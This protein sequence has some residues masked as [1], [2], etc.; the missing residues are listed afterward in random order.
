MESKPFFTLLR[1]RFIWLNL[2]FVGY[3][4]LLQPAVL[5]RLVASTQSEYP[6]WMM[7]G[8][9]LGAQAIEMVGLLLKRPASAFYTRRYPDPGDQGGCRD[10]AKVVLFVFTPI[11]HLC[12]AAMLTLVVFDLLKIGPHDEAAVLWQCLSLVLFFAILTK[13]AFFV[14]LMLSIGMGRS[15]PRQ[16]PKQTRP[17]WVDRL[18]LWLG[19]PEIN[20]ITLKDVLKDLVGD[21]LLLAFA[22]LAYT[23]SW[24]LITAGSP[25]RRQGTGRLFEYLGVSLFFFMMYFATRSVYLM[26]ELGIQQS[27]AARIFSWV[28][29]LVVWL[30]ALWSI[31]P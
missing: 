14:V 15:I 24:E 17:H 6:D 1:F 26:Q 30:S 16:P 21:L 12:F 25:L 11:L 28:S 31:S 10:N 23:A 29:F 19:P 22:A 8:I 5:Q 18:E 4:W 3:L 13:E 7:G 9:L 27:R 20:Q 2:L